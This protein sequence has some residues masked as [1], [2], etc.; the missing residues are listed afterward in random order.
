[1]QYHACARPEPGKTLFFVCD[2]QERFRPAIHGFQQIVNTANKLV[3]F[4]HLLDIPL[5]VTEQAPKSLGTT[6]AEIGI[7][8]E[9][10]RYDKTKFSML[11]D[12]IKE[13][14]AQHLGG[15]GGSVVIFGLEAHVCVLQTVFDLL[16][17]YQGK[18]QVHVVVDG[19][20]S[21]NKE[22]VPIAL[23]RIRQAGAFVTS[24]ESLMFQ[25]MGDASDPKFK[26]F[27]GLVKEKKGETKDALQVLLSPATVAGNDG[28]GSAKM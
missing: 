27:S 8:E 22:E 3:K 6:V 18:I 10:R 1:M 20:S 23:D 24:S 26:A 15:E 16:N 13:R 21:C 9:V 5:I 4:A 14:I 19:V 17:F 11:L 12:P 28:N 2:I 25:L 7:P